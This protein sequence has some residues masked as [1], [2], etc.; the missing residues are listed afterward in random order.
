MRLILLD[1]PGAG[2]GTQ[3]KRI[4]EKF[5]IVHISTGDILREELKKNSELGKKAGEYMQK[6]ELV[7]DD[8]IIEMIKNIIS[9]KE[10]I[11]N[12]EKSISEKSKKNAQNGF[13]MDGFPRTLNQ[14]KKFDEMLESLGLSIDKVINIEVKKEELVK[15]LSSRRVCHSCN[16]ICSLNDK[17]NI[18]EIKLGKCPVCGGELFQ[19]KD[20]SEDVIMQRLEVYENQTKPL[21]NYY[22]QKNLLVDIDGMGSED[23]ITERILS[24]L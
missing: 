7:P 19:R 16:N 1:P 2:K 14:A 22:K 5:N 3:A 12:N 4:A 15:R 8:L 21:I 17:K 6:G 23:E 11:S 18:D 24:S 9:N 20:D 13:L 10:N